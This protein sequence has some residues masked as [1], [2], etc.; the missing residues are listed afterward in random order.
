MANPVL[1]KTILKMLINAIF[2]RKIGKCNDVLSRD[3]TGC[4]YKV[5]F[6]HPDL[7]R[8]PDALKFHSLLFPLVKYLDYTRPRY[9]MHHNLIYL[10]KYNV[11]RRQSCLA[12]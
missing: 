12:S 4:R 3:S 10:D 9:V 5:V 7:I 6:C 1:A 8:I 11:T 2:S